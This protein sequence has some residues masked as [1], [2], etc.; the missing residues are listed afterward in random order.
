MIAWSGICLFWYLYVTTNLSI[1][2]QKG[3]LKITLMLKPFGVSI[4]KWFIHLSA[5][6]YYCYDIVQYIYIYI[7]IFFFIFFIFIF[8]LIQR[9]K[10]RAIPYPHQPPSRGDN[11]VSV[12]QGGTATPGATKQLLPPDRVL[13]ESYI[14]IYIYIYIY[15]RSIKCRDYIGR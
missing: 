1:I 11:T 10:A 7:Y 5:R 12:A 2:I 4:W 15:A 13:R 14:Y 3:A 8:F 9:V 6:V